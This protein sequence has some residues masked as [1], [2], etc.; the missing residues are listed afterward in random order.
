MSLKS[1]IQGIH[2]SKMTIQP[3]VLMGN[4][5][6][7]YDIKTIYR[8]KEGRCI[9]VGINGSCA[10]TLDC[11]PGQYCERGKCRDYKKLGEDCQH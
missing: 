10:R 11:E 8:C 7:K 2:A 1:Y 6:N 9:G 3:D 4:K 5:C